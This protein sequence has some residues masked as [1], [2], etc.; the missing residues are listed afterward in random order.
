MVIKRAEYKGGVTIPASKSQT[1]RALLIALLSRGKS[2]IRHPLISSDTLSCVNALKA[3]GAAVG[4]K[5]GEI[6]VD[7]EKLNTGEEKIVIDAGNSGT[8]TALILPILALFSTPF[9]VTG[10]EQLSSRPFLPLLES[11]EDLGAETESSGGFLPIY[12][13]GPIKGGETTIECRTSQYLSGLLLALPLCENDSGVHCSLLYEKPYVRMTE[14]W[15][16]KEHI[17]FNLS[18]DLMESRIEGGQKYAPI[19][20][21]IEGDFSSASFFFVLAAIHGTSIRVTGL[22]RLSTQG[23]KR[24]LEVLMSMGCSVKWDGMSVT[25]TGPEKIKGGDYDINDIPDALPALS[26]LASFSNEK[27]VFR[28][29]SQARLKETDRIKVMKKELEKLGADISEME[30]G[31]IIRGKGG[32]KGGV[33][34]GHGD[35]RVIMALSIAGTKT[36][37][38]TIID[39]VSAVNVTFPTFYSLLGDLEH[40]DG[41]NLLLNNR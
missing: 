8:T 15:L 30:D 12:I 22:E 41:S 10:D 33:V 19:D 3:I 27:T 4:I 5:D 7:S 17:E 14:W 34:S 37:E 28:N 24:I 29:V 39:D 36:E 40:E 9:V 18:D 16:K 31:L 35:H 23:D 25:V 20:E 1:I 21:Y 38:E 13:K 11:L 6:E 32:L 2:V 26:V